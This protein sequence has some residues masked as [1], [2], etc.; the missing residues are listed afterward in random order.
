MSTFRLKAGDTAPELRMQLLD[1]TTPV[2]L[3]TA[4]TVR[5]LVADTAGTVLIDG[6]AF[7]DAGQGDEPDPGATTGRGWC[8]YPWTTPL[9]AVGAHRAE[10]EITWS[11][12]TVQTF[13]PADYAAIIVTADLG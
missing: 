11:D 3:T 10:V 4:T 7:P 1:G 6:T 13:P 5:L 9:E 8:S 12:D 2:D